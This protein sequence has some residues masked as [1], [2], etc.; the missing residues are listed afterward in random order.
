ML[1][2][3]LRAR[4][5]LND[6]DRDCDRFNGVGMTSPRTRA[7]MVARLREKGIRDETVLAAMNAVPRHIF[8]E[9]SL[10][11]RAYDDTPLPI[12]YGQTISQPWV[13]ARMTE[14]ARAGKPL[15]TVL[16][17]GSDSGYQTAVLALAA[18]HIYTVERIGALVAQARRHLRE[19]KLTNVAIKHGD[20]SAAM[21]ESLQVDA[22]VVTAGATALPE[23]LL[24]HLEIGGRMVVPLAVEGRAELQRLTV[25]ERT[26]NGF[27]EQTLEAVRF[28]PLLPGTA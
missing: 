23:A 18:E 16:E 15:R 21:D 22:I 2:R 1:P 28:V 26:A 24:A 7:R 19:L 27:K 20:G 10:A 13:V 17:I 12:G 11:S 4:V 5:I 14:L 25:I 9:E 3:G 6:K 8:V